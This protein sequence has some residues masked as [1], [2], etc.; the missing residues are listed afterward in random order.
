MGS[1][2][3][4]SKGDIRS[5]DYGSCRGPIDEL[6]MLFPDNARVFLVELSLWI[7]MCN[8]Y[9]HWAQ[10]SVDITYIRLFEALG[11]WLLYSKTLF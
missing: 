2:I 4:L 8:G 5:L 1:I 10:K 3:G 7:Q 9:L 6:S 11:C